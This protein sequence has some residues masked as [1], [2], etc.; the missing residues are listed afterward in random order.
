MSP[1]SLRNGFALIA[2]ATE[3]L[4]IGL[5]NDLP[6]RLPRE[7]AYFER[8]TSKIPASFLKST[9]GQEENANVKN[10]VIMGRRTWE[11]IPKRLRPLKNRFNIVISRDSSYA[12]NEMPNPDICHVTSLEQALSVIDETRH[13]RTFIVGGSQI[14]DIAM[15]L[16]LCHHILLTRIYAKIQCDTFFPVVDEAKYKLASHEELE[17]FVEDSVPRGR[18]EE[19]GIEYEFTMYTRVAE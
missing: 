6:W 4:G 13:P 3:E 10:A 12:K 8:V 16:P 2:A 11:S 14:Y 5:N 18:V 15:R 9:P 19:K 17:Q 7:V 1:T